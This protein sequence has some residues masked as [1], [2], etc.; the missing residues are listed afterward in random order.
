MPR[1]LGPRTTDE[2]PGSA[3]K[4]HQ[5]LT[6][7]V[8]ASTLAPPVGS[9]WRLLLCHFLVGDIF[10]PRL[11]SQGRGFLFYSSSSSSE[12]SAVSAPGYRGSGGIALLGVDDL[13]GIPVSPLSICC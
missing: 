7:G 9:L 10:H 11:P 6:G 1:R 13:L 2:V 5:A 12:T 8:P 4:C 3:I